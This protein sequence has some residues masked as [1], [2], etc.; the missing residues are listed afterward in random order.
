MG[1]IYQ[2]AS[3]VIAWLGLPGQ[4]DSIN[5][6]VGTTIQEGLSFAELL[7]GTTQTRYYWSRGS[8]WCQKWP[9]PYAVN[10]VTAIKEDD[11][12]W[13]VLHLLFRCSY[14]QRLWIVQELVLASDIVLQ[15]GVSTL[16]F[17]AIEHIC[18]QLNNRLYGWI[19]ALISIDARPDTSEVRLMARTTPFEIY[20][21][22]VE[23]KFPNCTHTIF[24]LC[25][26]YREANCSDL[27]DKIYGLLGMSDMCCRQN[28]K[29][30]YSSSPAEL[31]LM[32]VEH[33][34][35]CHNNAGLESEDGGKGSS[36]LFLRY[37]RGVFA[38]F[39]HDSSS[40][41][42]HIKDDH[43]IFFS[44][45][46]FS[47]ETNVA[48]L[49][50]TALGQIMSFNSFADGASAEAESAPFVNYVNL[51]TDASKVELGD[52]V[53]QLNGQDMIVLRLSGVEGRR[54]LV[55]QVSVAPEYVDPGKEC[56]RLIN[57]PLYMNVVSLRNL[58]RL[59]DAN[60][61]IYLMGKRLHQEFESIYRMQVH[62]MIILSYPW[63][64]SLTR[65]PNPWLIQIFRSLPA[66]RYI[67]GL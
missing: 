10:T 27:L 46:D 11:A 57:H 37:L 26:R 48:M 8:G 67:G 52:L 28:V 13:G 39:Q 63:L 29:V 18:S 61:D 62:F 17:K 49:D 2:N 53:H 51:T 54:Q 35:L 43:R 42:Q 31:C 22:R 33:Q 4:P 44:G 34:L 56:L 14:F 12:R 41:W 38:L 60:R 1:R 5:S 32:I 40:R 3:R 36:N 15:S 65:V 66:F 21:Q 45:S 30:D 9:D 24:D 50:T 64:I 47:D 19:G 20:K 16:A 7:Y 59:V 58:C 55:A 25:Y 6:L 23:R